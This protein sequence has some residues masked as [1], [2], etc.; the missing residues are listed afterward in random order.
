MDSRTDHLADRSQEPFLAHLVRMPLI[1]VVEAKDHHR[2]VR[3]I[4]N[5]ANAEAPE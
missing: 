1:P 5:G 3:Q 4:H 2:E